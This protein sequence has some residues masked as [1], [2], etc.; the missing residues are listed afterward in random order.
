M[1]IDDIEP[2]MAVACIINRR[3]DRSRYGRTMEPGDVINGVR[4]VPGVVKAVGQFRSQQ[5]G[6]CGTVVYV[7]C[8]YGSRVVLVTVPPPPAPWSPP[9]CVTYGEID[10]KAKVKP[11]KDWVTL[12]VMPAK[13]YPWQRF[14]DAAADRRAVDA[15][16][17]VEHE[18]LAIVGERL[19][20]IVTR[21]LPFL[22]REG[23]LKLTCRE[24]YREQK[25]RLQ[26]DSGS[27]D[28]HRFHE[29]LSSK[30]PKECAEYLQ[31]TERLR[32]AR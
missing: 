7:P 19:D 8:D 20:A 6:I 14:V 32:C 15:E 1:K 5:Q 30:A 25:F 27:S 2:G 13:I 29:W 18:R 4:A 11:K 17:A 28:D 3:E 31:I 21:N 12:E 22:V 24:K 9:P 26:A 16:M 10:D 23:M